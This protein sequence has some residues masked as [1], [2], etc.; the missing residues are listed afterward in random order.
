MD[1]LRKTRDTLTNIVTENDQLK[2]TVAKDGYGEPA[3]IP[4][5]TRETEQPVAKN[6]EP[7]QHLEISSNGYP[8]EIYDHLEI[9][10]GLI[11]ELCI[12]KNILTNPL[13]VDD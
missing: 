5:S 12:Q 8:I 10:L 7:K 6:K 11:E 2:T 4:H 1:K 3:Q 13:E 9:E